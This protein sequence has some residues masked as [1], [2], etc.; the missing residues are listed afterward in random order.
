MKF[1]TLKEEKVLA[2]LNSVCRIKTL[3]TAEL[4]NFIQSYEVFSRQFMHP[5]EWFTTKNTAVMHTLEYMFE[6]H[7]ERPS[8][9]AVAEEMGK[10][11]SWLSHMIIEECGMS[12]TDMLALVR[13]AEFI[14]LLKENDISISCMS[15]DLGFEDAYSLCRVFKSVTGLTAKTYRKWSLKVEKVKMELGRRK[16]L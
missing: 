11:R 5:K 1:K 7:R 16:R 15:Y 14:N 13:V 10:T 9:K 6:H 2:M 3:S 8:L 4:E 12:Y